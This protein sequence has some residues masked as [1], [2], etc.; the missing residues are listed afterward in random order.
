MPAIA[1][2]SQ[3]GGS[4]KSTLAIHLAAAAG[5]ALLI[6]TDP[7]RSATGWWQSREADLPEVV[8]VP[9]ADVRRALGLGRRAWTFI[10]TPPQV[11]EAARLVAEAA[12]YVLLP[13]RPAILD[14]RAIHAT[15]TIVQAAGKP[16]AIVINAGLPGRGTAEAGPVTDARKAMAVYPLPVSPVA[17]AQ[18][19]AF[20]HALAAGQVAAEFEPGG[21][22]AGEIERLWRW[23]RAKTASTEP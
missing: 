3:K 11:G 15:V 21:R 22:A 7:Q 18:R 5:D 12:D 20:A 10:D 23:V 16:G 1:L 2:L 13:V 8:A 19:A 4:G 9:A 6:D 14:L 17:V